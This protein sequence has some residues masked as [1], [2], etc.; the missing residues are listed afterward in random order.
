[1]KINV[2]SD[3][4]IDI[5]PYALALAPD[6][7]VVVVAGDVCERLDRS[8]PWLAAE[9]KSRGYEV[10][11]VPG[12]HDFYGNRAFGHTSTIDGDLVYA[13]MLAQSLG[14]HLLAEGEAT[15]IQGV[16]YVGATLWTDYSV[17]GDRVASMAAAGDKVSGMNDHK[18]IKVKGS[19]YGKFRPAEALVEHRRQLAAMEAV[20]AT[21]F[22]G[23]TVVVTHHAP[24][25]ASLRHGEVRE[26]LDGSYASDLT[27]FIERWK[28]ALWIHGHVHKNQDYRV[29]DT[30]IVANPRGY[31]LTKGRGKDEILEIE[32]PDH[33]P[34]LTVD[35]DEPP[36]GWGR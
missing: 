25:P 10:V 8:L 24:H 16:R 35:V 36:T 21:P 4:H 3:L 18:R 32:N 7:K 1:V 15:V 27:A 14:I 22:D 6:A 17:A 2:L 28:P 30:R 20:L 12:N 11:Y 31:V 33:V 19:G 5:H 26:L 9:I 13:R 29:Q 34:D 23:P